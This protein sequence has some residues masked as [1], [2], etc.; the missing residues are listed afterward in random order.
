[1]DAFGHSSA[2]PDLPSSRLP[3]EGVVAI[4]I[5]PAKPKAEGTQQ[6]GRAKHRPPEL[7]LPDVDLFVRPAEVQGRFGLAEDRVAKRNRH[8]QRAT[9]SMREE[10]PDQAAMEFHNS[11]ADLDMAAGDQPEKANCQA[12]ER[13]G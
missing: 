9:R 10:P 5:P 8:R 2:S 11:A 4:P 6:V 3:L 12:K 13:V 1:M 7:V